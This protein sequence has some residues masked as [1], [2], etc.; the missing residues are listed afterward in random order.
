MNAQQIVEA[1]RNRLSVQSHTVTHPLIANVDERR[2]RAE[3]ADSRTAISKLTGVM[4]DVL[5]YPNGTWS[6]FR[7][8]EIDVA[9]TCGYQAAMTCS[10][11]PDDECA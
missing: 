5:A 10:R 6:D 9:R 4:P 8:R 2:L 11:N 7:Q 1:S 3:L